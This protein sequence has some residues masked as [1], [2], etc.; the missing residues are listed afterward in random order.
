M[1]KISYVC[2]FFALMMGTSCHSDKTTSETV[3]VI[4]MEDSI[5]VDSSEENKQTAEVED[6]SEEDGT[7]EGAVE[8]DSVR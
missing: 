3:N 2:A 6:I 1:K 7:T 8:K 4:S 5:T